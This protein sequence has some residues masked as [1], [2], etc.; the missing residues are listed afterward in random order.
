MQNSKETNSHFKLPPPGTEWEVLNVYQSI[1]HEERQQREKEFAAVR[2]AKFKQMLDQQIKDAETI[3]AQLD[4]KDKQFHQYMVEDIQKFE[5]I[6]RSKLQAEK[7]KHDEELRV[8]KQQIDAQTAVR[9]KEKQAARKLEEDSI[10][11]AK[12]KAQFEKE[13]LAA[14]KLQE[15]DIRKQIEVSNEANRQRLRDER[16]KAV[17]EEHRMNKEYEA[18]LDREAFERDNAFKKRMEALEKFGANFASTGA[19]KAA[20]E[21][22]I[23]FELFLLKETKKKEEADAAAIA[24]KEAERKAKEERARV[25]NARMLEWR[26]RIDQMEKQQEEKLACK[27]KSDLEQYQSQ[28]AEEYR[29]KKEKQVAYRM[30]LREQQAQKQ[31][32]HMGTPMESR[33]REFNMDLLT[34]AVE[35]IPNIIDTVTQRRARSASGGQR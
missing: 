6:E 4:K 29:L 32:A 27:F 22:E 8:R 33:E 19:G 23:K 34:R 7:A 13:R 14:K 28:V 1:V 11:F 25:E 30:Q 12:E 2:K 16:A 5:E 24:R 35:E 18:K 17:E 15:S 10:R 21:E 26:T 31:R 3:K 20:K 9:E